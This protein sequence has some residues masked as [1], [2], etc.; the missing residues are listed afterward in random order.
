MLSLFTPTIFSR[1]SAIFKREQLFVIGSKKACCVCYILLYLKITALLTDF[2]YKQH[3]LFYARSQN[4]FVMSARLSV[5]PHGKTPLP[6]D[7]VS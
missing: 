5:L 6:V 3:C 2:L 4:C 1:H 7:A